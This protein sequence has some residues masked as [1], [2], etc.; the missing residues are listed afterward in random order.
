MAIRRRE[1]LD[2]FLQPSHEKGELARDILRFLS[3]E[4]VC[5]SVSEEYTLFP[6][7]RANAIETLR[8]RVEDVAVDLFAN[9]CNAQE[10]RFCTKENSAFLFD[11]GTFCEQG[12]LLWGNPLCSQ[13]G[14]V[15]AKLRTEKLTMILLVP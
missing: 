14:R 4:R 6:I 2:E 7:K 10:W 15:V 1:S 13:L 11:W 8:V 5:E 9:E 3:E 12:N